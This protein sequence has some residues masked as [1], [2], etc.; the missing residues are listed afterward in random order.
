MEGAHARAEEA[1]R[2]VEGLVTCGRTCAARERTCA[3]SEA[4]HLSK[5]QSLKE[6]QLPPNHAASAAREA[7]Q[8]RS[9]EKVQGVR[10]ETFLDAL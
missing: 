2:E 5:L 4:E 6:V 8:L 3:A 9:L 1:A 10:E 7:A